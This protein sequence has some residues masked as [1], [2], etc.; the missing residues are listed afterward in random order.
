MTPETKHCEDCCLDL[1]LKQFARYQGKRH[2]L[3]RT[4]LAVDTRE[5]KAWVLP[6]V[7]KRRAEGPP[8]RGREDWEIAVLERLEL[9]FKDKCALLQR[10]GR[11]A[12]RKSHR[13]GSNAGKPVH[14][15]L[16][17]PWKF[18][19]AALELTQ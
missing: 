7:E 15:S 18:G 13:Y 17:R 19:I 5:F 6:Y 1:P 2:P 10:V 11:D 9:S 14:P 12:T 3:C 16:V 8:V 4:C